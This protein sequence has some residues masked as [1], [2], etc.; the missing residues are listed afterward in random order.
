MIQMLDLKRMGD[1]KYHSQK[2]TTNHSQSSGNGVGNIR[3]PDLGGLDDS[4][5]GGGGSIQQH[6]EDANLY[7]KKGISNS[8]NFRVKN[9][10]NTRTNSNAFLMEKSGSIAGDKTSGN[11]FGNY[12][13]MGF[14]KIKVSKPDVET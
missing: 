2:L 8:S 3:D 1:K 7:G 10:N 13:D 5:L 11:P 12:D 6:K 4:I 9:G 14:A